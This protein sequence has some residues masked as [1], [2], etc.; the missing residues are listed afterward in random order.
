A[1]FSDALHDL[2]DSLSL[3]LSWIFEK[4]SKKK[5]SRSFTYGFGRFSILG[6]LINGLVLLGG[7]AFVL[8]RAIPALWHPNEPNAKG[9][10]AMAVLG[11]LVNGAAVF[12]L[13]KG[14]SL[15]E[16]VVLFHLLEDLFGWV[17]VL[18]GSVIIY[19][20]DLTIIDPILSFL[21][22]G[23]ILFNVFKNIKEALMIFLQAELNPQKQQGLLDKIQQIEGVDSLHDPHF[24]TL[25]GR[26]NI[27]SLHL[28]LQGNPNLESCIEIKEQ[29]RSLLQNKGYNHSTLE[30]ET[31]DEACEY[32]NC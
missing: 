8:Y 6:A 24:W 22:A 4:L 5:R 18:I 32:E 13:K 15:N 16:R 11:I 23:V 25:D 10:L 3:A 7:S 29:C 12:R 17:A 21:I 1:I 28:V 14:D 27:A 9:M 26:Q 19:F 30:L 20:W 31:M 2:G